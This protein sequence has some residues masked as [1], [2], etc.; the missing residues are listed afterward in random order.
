MSLV[1]DMMALGDFT[2]STINMRISSIEPHSIRQIRC[3][4]YMK[5]IIIGFWG[6]LL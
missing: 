2:D 3:V 6:T 1:Y 5:D 4:Q